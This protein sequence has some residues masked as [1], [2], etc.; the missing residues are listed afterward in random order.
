MKFAL[1]PREEGGWT[2]EQF[3]TPG[4][5]F[6]TLCKSASVNRGTLFYY[7]VAPDSF[8][9]YL[10]ARA[11]SESFRIPAGWTIW[12]GEK[13]EPRAIPARETIRYDLETLPASEYR[14]LADSFGP[15]LVAEVNKLTSNF[16]KQLIESVPEDLPEG[17]KAD[18]LKRLREERLE[19]ITRSAQGYAIA[20]FNTAL[21]ASKVRGDEEVRLEIRPPEIPHIRVFQP[22]N[23]PSAPKPKPDSN[24]K[25][26]PPKKPSTGGNQ[27]IL[28]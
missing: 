21:A 25:P 1:G 3:L 17:Q 12:A 19:F 9:A 14:K 8:D 15:F 23:F 18:F 7:Y 2:P 11:K 5:E 22:A 24:E 27:L 6:E 16:E 26:P 10:Q 4:S 13:F 28:D 20:P